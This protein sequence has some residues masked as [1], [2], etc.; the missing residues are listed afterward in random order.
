M[1]PVEMNT[2][3][4]RDLYAYLSGVSHPFYS[5]TFEQDVT[6]LYEYVH[7]RGL[8]FYYALVYLCT[9]AINEI[10]NFRYTIRNGQ[11]LEAPRREP[12]FTDM[13][14]G[15]EVYHI[16]TMKA[17]E[18]LD[19]FCHAA[20]ERSRN[21]RVF[22][23]PDGDDGELIYFSCLPWMDVT[24]LTNER[25]FDRDDSVPR[26]AWGKYLLREGRRVLHISV[27][28]NH[29]LVDGYHVGCLALKLT[30]KIRAVQNR[31]D[32]V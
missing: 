23:E 28:V 1:K 32:A 9:E 4:R 29:R 11:V 17:G 21:Q 5:V 10:E 25:D 18:S 24:G 14:E 30:E 16:V 20:R 31:S 12:S 22:I 27:E 15:A 6:E 3:P 8:S 2:W 7:A 19:A 26:V 13:H